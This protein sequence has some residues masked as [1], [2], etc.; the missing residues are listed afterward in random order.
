MTSHCGSQ[1]I[2]THILSKTYRCKDNKTMTFRQLIEYN[3][4]MFFFKY[5]AQN[6]KKR[7]VSDLLLSFQKALYEVKAKDLHLDLIMFR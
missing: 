6:E 1:T 3:K 2:T 5:H 4:K 7:L